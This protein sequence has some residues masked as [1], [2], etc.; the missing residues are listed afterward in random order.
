MFGLLMI[1]F[2]AI[3]AGII[4]FLNSVGEEVNMNINNFAVLVAENEGLKK[5]I[6]IA[7]IKEVLKVIN[8]LLGGELY[9]LIKKIEVKK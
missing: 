7:Q 5:Q 2:A 3:L 9:R 4:L 1:G 6:S 8:A